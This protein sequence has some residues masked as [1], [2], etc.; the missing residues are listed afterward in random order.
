MSRDDRAWIMCSAASRAASASVPAAFFARG[1]SPFTTQ[2]EP[3]VS[4]PTRTGTARRGSMSR[5]STVSTSITPSELHSL[6]YSARTPGVSGTCRPKME[7]CRGSSMRCPSMLEY[8]R[9]RARGSSMVTAPP[10]SDA[11]ALARA[12]RSPIGT[13]DMPGVSPGSTQLRTA[14]V[15]TRL[16]WLQLIWSGIESSATPAASARSATSPCSPCSFITTAEAFAAAARF[17]SSAPSDPS[18][19]TPTA[20]ATEPSSSGVRSTGS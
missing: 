10:T 3:I 2:I 13:L 7:R 1:C 18:G 9:T 15:R 20:S 19:A 16:K 11:M 4:P 17:R 12:N 5:S 14:V 8:A 6:R